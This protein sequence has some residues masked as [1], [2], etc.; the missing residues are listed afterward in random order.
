MLHSVASIVT[1]FRALCL[2][3]HD[4]AI[5]ASGGNP[6]S[7]EG[8]RVHLGQSVQPRAGQVLIAFG[9]HLLAVRLASPLGRGAP[10]L[11]LA[12]TSLYCSAALVGGS[13]VVIF[14]GSRFVARLRQTDSSVNT[15]R[16]PFA[17][18]P[19]HQWVIRRLPDY[20]AKTNA[21]RRGVQHGRQHTGG[22][23]AFVRRVHTGNDQE[24]PGCHRCSRLKMLGAHGAATSVAFQVNCWQ[25]RHGRLLLEHLP[26]RALVT[27]AHD[28]VMLGVDT[29]GAALGGFDL[30]RYPAAAM[31]LLAMSKV[32]GSGTK[33]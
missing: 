28:R 2:R 16:E 15:K 26:E 27:P 12:A 7:A 17:Y 3:A 10:G 9:R 13:F 31:P 32:C 21:R 1:M 8:S 25:L 24:L 23:A 20:C 22:S 6:L 18:L 11:L 4:A 33:R 19:K 14:Q 5:A 29:R 30:E